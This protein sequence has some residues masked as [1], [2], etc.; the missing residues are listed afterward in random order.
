MSFSL[1]YPTNK[2]L[3]EKQTWSSVAEKA[4]SVGARR[5]PCPSLDKS[6]FYPS[7]TFTRSSD[8]S[9]PTSPTCAVCPIAEFLQGT[10]VKL[11]Y[12]QQTKASPNIR[13][14]L[15]D[16]YCAFHEPRPWLWEFSNDPEHIP[17]LG[18]NHWEREPQRSIFSTRERYSDQLSSSYNL[19]GQIDAA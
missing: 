16:D 10:P 9:F 2:C 4:L 1:A 13:F 3:Q 5:V 14:C 12:R 17:G 6:S 8:L 18:L 15:L 19:P 11:D 7:R